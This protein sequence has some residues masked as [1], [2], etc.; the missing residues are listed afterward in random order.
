MHLID[1]LLNGTNAIPD[2]AFQEFK[3]KNGGPI[4]NWPS[5]IYNMGND[6]ASI[7]IDKSNVSHL[8]S[9]DEV[10]DPQ[11]SILSAALTLGGPLAL[12]VTIDKWY[13]L[14]SKCVSGANVAIV[15][16]L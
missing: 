7:M 11:R 5:S 2:T 12:I 16:F 3:W 10:S 1:I 4:R 8:F 13:L 6:E 9:V 15:V 14:F